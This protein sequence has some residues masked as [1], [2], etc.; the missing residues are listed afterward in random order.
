MS[1]AKLID[2]SEAIELLRSMEMLMF[3]RRARAL[4]TMWSRPEMWPIPKPQ[5]LSL[6]EWQQQYIATMEDEQ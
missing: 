6:V 1:D 3:E 2:I 5:G 4:R